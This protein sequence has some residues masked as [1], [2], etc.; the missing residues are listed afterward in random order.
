MDEICSKAIE[1]LASRICIPVES[2]DGI[3]VMFYPLMKSRPMS[4]RM[5]NAGTPFLLKRFGVL[6]HILFIKSGSVC[7]GYILN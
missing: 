3:S 5:F 1:V 7:A 6:V 4:A 2:R